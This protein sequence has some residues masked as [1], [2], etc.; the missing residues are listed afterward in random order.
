[1]NEPER[2]ADQLKCHYEVEKE[3]AARLLKASRQERRGMYAE[4]YNELF[5]RVPHHPQ[6]TQ[7]ESKGNS[8]AAAP[9]QLRLLE[10]FLLPETTF[11]EIG[12]GDCGVALAAAR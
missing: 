2:S 6:L 1:M 7:K 5:H 10:P 4:V 3:L 11:L 12:P 8:T 9:P